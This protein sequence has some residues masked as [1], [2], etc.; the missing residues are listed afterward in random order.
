MT[1]EL[2]RSYTKSSRKDIEASINVVFET[3]KVAFG[4]KGSGPGTKTSFAK[5]KYL[6]T[7]KKLLQASIIRLANAGPAL[8]HVKSK[9]SKSENRKQSAT[10]LH[11]VAVHRA[12][13]L[14]SHLRGD[15]GRALK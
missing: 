4:V 15:Q 2:T 9:C 6:F 10:V 1:K 8:Q 13:R 14:P 11:E 5:Q 3:S 12:S 7:A